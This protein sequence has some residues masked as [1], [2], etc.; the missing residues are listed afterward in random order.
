MTIVIQNNGLNQR[1]DITKGCFLVRH[2][3]MSLYLKFRYHN[4]KF[5]IYPARIKYKVCRKVVLKVRT[6]TRVISLDKI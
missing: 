2:N 6:T 4:T 5:V 1:M 3:I